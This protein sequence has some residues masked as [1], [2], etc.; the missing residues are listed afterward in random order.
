MSTWNPRKKQHYFSGVLTPLML[1]G[2]HLFT[3]PPQNSRE[4]KW[5]LVPTETLLN[6]QPYC[7]SRAA[8]FACH[9]SNRR[10]KSG[11]GYYMK[12]YVMIQQELRRRGLDIGAEAPRMGE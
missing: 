5:A 6:A 3:G 4:E 11:T 9:T 2:T 12:W 8:H 7:L 1:L 10:R